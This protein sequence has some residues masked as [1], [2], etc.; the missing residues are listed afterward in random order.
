MSSKLREALSKAGIALSWAT[1][2]HLTEDDAEKYLAVVDAALAEPVLN[3]EVG[4]PQ[5]Q[6]ERWQ[7]FC[8]EHHEQWKPNK[9]LTEIQRCNCPCYQGNACNWFVWAQMPYKKGEINE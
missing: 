8:L 4:T 7:Q 1:H 5:N 3:C 9:S 2:G 6:I